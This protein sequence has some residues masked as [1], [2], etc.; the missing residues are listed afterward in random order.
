MDTKAGSRRESQRRAVAQYRRLAIATCALCLLTA[1]TARAAEPFARIGSYAATFAGMPQGVRNIGMG[2]TGAA[3]VSGF[4][5]GY[6]NPA[7][8]A[9]S[10]ATTALG[11]YEDWGAS[12]SLSDIRVI[13]GFPFLADSSAA[14]R[15]GGSIGYSRL[16]MDPQVVRT[17][18]LPEGTGETFDADDWL[19]SG[20]AAAS[21]R[22][23]WVQVGVGGTA[24][25][26]Q[27]GLAG[28]DASMWS[29]DLGLIAAFPVE[30][31]GGCVRPRTG[32][33]VLNLDTGMD[34]DNR[35][36]NIA[37][38]RRGALGFDVVTA[39]MNLGGRA[40]PAMVFSFDYDW[41][42]RED[43]SYVDYGA[44]VEVS[45]VGLVH[46]RYGTMANVSSTYG[47]G[48]GWDYGSWLFRLDY[49]R[50]ANAERDTFGAMVGARW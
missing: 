29:F 39:S 41:I 13:S 37:N 27:Q 45:L 10:E 22:R 46:A 35:E 48:L 43:Y 28:G 47:F 30:V 42:N 38:E 19:L 18:Y 1:Q 25:F 3:D 9:W 16:A 5:S 23:G 21:W 50:E 17:I 36:S 20:S 11:S 12:L 44:G 6:F 8:L 33:S 31:A 14:W 7:S 49:A 26:I 2:A 32:C 40:V 34:Y 15:F 24:K 4:S